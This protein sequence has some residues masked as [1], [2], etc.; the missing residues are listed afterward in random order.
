MRY[1]GFQ[2]SA[3][4]W[5]L[6]EL[7]R[8]RHAKIL[9]VTKNRKQAA[10]LRED[11]EFFAAPGIISSLPAWD[12][13]PFES[14]SPQPHITAERLL[15]LFKM[16][17]AQSFIIVTPIE[18]LLQK[19]LPVSFLE[20][21][22]CKVVTRSIV[23]RDGL[24][25]KIKSL[26]Y[27]EVS[28]VE[29]VGEVAIRGTV[30]DLY[31]PSEPSPVRIE[32]ESGTVRSI[33]RFDIETQRTSSNT[34]SILATPVRELIELGTS[35][36]SESEIRFA[37]Q[38]LEARSKEYDVPSRELSRI[39]AQ[40]R[41]VSQ[42]PGAESLLAIFTTF[43][44]LFEYFPNDLQVVL[45]EK[46][47]LLKAL[48]DFEDII[49]EREK[50]LREDHYL[51]PTRQELFLS[52]IEL[53]EKLLATSHHIFDDIAVRTDEQKE[54]VKHLHCESLI[55]LTTKL[56][57]QIGS[58]D[59]LTPLIGYLN[60]VRGDGARVCIAIGSQVRAE[61]V[62][63]AL[64]DLDV[65]APVLEGSVNE[66]LY[67]AHPAPVVIAVGHLSE[68]V[69]LVDQKTVFIAE[70]DLFSERSYRTFRKSKTSIKKLLGSLA[71]LKEG[72]FVVH[73]DYGIGRYHGLT[74]K[75]VGD[76]ESDFL[77]IDYADSKLFL[78]VHNIAKIQKFVAAEGQ[79]PALDK[80]GS[81]R[82]VNTKE[83]IKQAVLP[84]AGDLIKL[85]A[86]RSVAKGW[87]YEPPGA[88]DERFADSF[89][90]NET[91]DQLKAIDEILADMGSDKPMDRLVCGDVGF[92]KTEVAM[93]AAFKCLQHARQVA[94]LVPTTLLAEQHYRSFKA[95]FE[96]Y[97]MKIG[98]VS[99]FVSNAENKKTLD[100]LASGELD[101]IIGT[102]RLLQRDVVFRDIGLLIIDEEHRFGVKQKEQLKRFR[103]EVDVLTLT[104]TPIPR[105]LHMS[106][107]GVR[108]ASIISTPPTDRR[109]IRTYIATFDEALARDA[110][111]RELQRQG[112]S[113]FVHNRVD[114]IVGITHRLRELVPEARFEFAHGQMS[115][116]HLENI[117]HRFINKEFDVLVTTTIIESGIDIPNANTI[118][119]DRADRYGLAQL[120]QLRGR[121]GRSKAQAYA[122]FI[123][124]KAT[125]L[126]SDAQQRLKAIQ[127]L[128]DLGLGFNLA[129]RDLE[130]RGAGNLLGKEQSGNVL[131]VGFELYC[132]ILKE[133]VLHLKGDEIEL[134][135]VLEPEIK[136]GF[137]AFI[138]EWYIPDISERLVL[139]QRLAS[140][141]TSEEM[142]ELVAETHDR[143]GPIPR[144]VYE[145][146]ELM[147][148]RATLRS[149]G[150]ARAEGTTERISLA[151][152]PR[153]R[154]ELP[155]ILALTSNQPK[156]YSFGKNLTLTLREAPPGDPSE[157]YWKI[158][159]LLESIGQSDTSKG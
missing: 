120:Y 11:L 65:E 146:S 147:R 129:V 33:R 99:R 128:D 5:L 72:D 154:I 10:T 123:I 113:F 92:G 58:G 27:R 84:L 74:H 80:L 23:S 105:T 76:A 115:D 7:Q 42:I 34:E 102:H 15:T 119:I 39:L 47:E 156:L 51:I 8:T 29:E 24:S 144:E 57:T 126:S 31:P 49:D 87:R 17:H 110:I 135:E 30:I 55:T 56:K 136:F 138:P 79:K 157:L 133:A 66:W 149:Y 21:A 103:R 148:L 73:V 122:Y 117:M 75:E 63:R 104:A 137:S 109:V 114:S 50:R 159:S 25:A 45:D 145:F 13:L 141:R 96:G 35:A 89:A 107:L 93:R 85:Y 54:K 67:A 4:P 130:I 48:E 6:T 143:F 53:T 132:K 97:S 64:L 151:F 116:V 82:W 91:T 106:L 20:S 69:Y 18:A 68:G 90:F 152:S 78:P 2:G 142:D 134:E 131:A 112:Q 153:A 98:V 38:K 22:T 70:Q 32:F 139:Y 44:T 108:D 83:K 101:I 59:A 36:S 140:V 9:V 16:R 100:S 111:L 155:K 81:N 1:I 127:S 28:L 14:V 125:K 118:I 124:P 46:T 43:S 158:R 12:T 40:L 150:V 94:V 88:E 41:D 19:V 62:K 52:G 3:K 60:R 86:Q 77:R 26:G 61:R 121:V 95:R 37:T 71:Q